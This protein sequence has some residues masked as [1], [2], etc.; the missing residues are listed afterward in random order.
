MS[1]KPLKGGR[2]I[3][4]D[5]YV[6]EGEDAVY[7]ED[8]IAR[9]VFGWNGRMFPRISLAVHGGWRRDDAVALQGVGYTVACSYKSNQG[10]WWK[11]VDVPAVLLKELVEILQEI[12]TPLSKSG[13]GK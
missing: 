9:R 11:E 6:E 4:P 5:F 3:D 13:E 7:Q 8:A 1:W 12:E 10:Q 2:A